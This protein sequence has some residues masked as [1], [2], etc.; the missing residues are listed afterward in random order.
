MA[1]NFWETHANFPQT[2]AGIYQQTPVST[3]W[4]SQLFPSNG[5]TYYGDRA[6]FEHLAQTPEYGPMF[7]AKLWYDGP[8]KKGESPYPWIAFN[9][10][11]PFPE[12]TLAD[13]WIK[14]VMRNVTWDYVTFAEAK[15]GLGGNTPY[16]NDGVVSRENIYRREWNQPNDRNLRHGRAILEKI[17]YEPEWWR[18]PKAQAPQQFGYNVCPLEFKPGKVTATLVGYVDDKRGGDWRAGFVGVDGEGNPHYGKVFGPGDK[19]SFDASGNIKELYLVVCAVPRKIMSIDMC[20]DFR[21]PEQEPFPYKVQLLGCEPKDVMVPGKPTVS[22]KAHVNGGG[23]VADS[24]KVE[25]TAYVGPGAQ[26]LDRAEVTGNARIE[27]FAVV[28]DDAKVAGNAIVSGHALVAG[29]ATVE[30]NAK[31][32]DYGKVMGRT[33]VEGNAKILEY[34]SMDTQKTCTDNVTVKGCSYV[35]G[36]N[37]SGIAMLDGFYAKGQDITQGKWFTWSWGAGK[38][39][40]EINEDFDGIYADYEF[41]E[42]HGWMAIDSFGATWGYLVNGAKVEV[43]KG[44]GAL[45]LNGKDQFV[46]LQKDVADMRDAT[47]K[48]RVMWQ[49]GKNERLFEFSN[50]RGDVAYLTPSDGGRCEFVLRVGATEQRLSAPALTPGKWTDVTVALRDGVGTLVLD[51]KVIGNSSSMKLHL[52]DIRATEC[53]LGGGRKG[54]YFKG[55]IDCFMV[56][57]VAPAGNV[58][59][60]VSRSASFYP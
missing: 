16:G 20:G 31:V 7:I 23:F 17:P 12:R 29:H 45:S 53:L 15:D 9:R 26:V 47:I 52:D 35:Y 32:R 4:T 55:M 24:A 37:Q 51:G 44:E 34:A 2:Y 48:A 3:V 49:G 8:A 56:Y 57:A 46:E 27:D 13:E 60:K 22:G 5:R 25:A 39:P 6:M 21:S 41:N 33:T 14:T 43:M 40:G 50:D 11:N 54:G 36:G 38:N 18:V 19:Q 58:P 59:L 28:R 42:P 10:I 1:G 30:G